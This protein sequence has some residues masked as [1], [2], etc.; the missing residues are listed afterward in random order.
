MPYIIY[1]SDETVLV[2]LADGQ[3]D[4][5]TTSLDLV[6][7]NVNNYGQYINGNFIKILTNFASTSSPRS[8]LLGQIWYDKS[9]KRLTVHNGQEFVPAYG[10][11][12]S[13]TEPTNKAS[14]DLWYNTNTNQMFVWDGSEFKLVGPSLDSTVGKFGIQPLADA[15]RVIDSSTSDPKN[16][17]VIYSYGDVIGFV[18]TSS[19]SMSLADSS[20]FLGSSETESVVE[21]LTIFNDIEIKGD[22]YVRGETR[23]PIK[24][25]TIYFNITPFGNPNDSGASAS[26][27]QSR[28]DAANSEL[29]N[30]I[31]PKL[32]PVITGPNEP[33]AYAL[34]SEVRV[35]CSYNNATAVRRFKLQE[36]SPG[37]PKWEPLNLY[38]NPLTGNNDNIIR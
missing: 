27:N 20:E 26:T 13:N 21:G 1:N 19:F 25:L 24:H 38:Y 33:Y 28:I 18:S 16:V 10:T 37:N 31:L 22:I 5:E 35:L 30:N 36:L 2:T 14:G 7:K 12:V 15:D 3:V 4:F 29:K 17:G 9:N 34:N 11:Y 32:F 8:P 23:T 6:G